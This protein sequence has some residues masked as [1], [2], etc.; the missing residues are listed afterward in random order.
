MIILL[1]LLTTAAVLQ[2][3]VRAV[4]DGHNRIMLWSWALVVLSDIIVLGML[5]R[6]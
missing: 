2:Y 1:I 5:I 4:W 3:Q 6:G